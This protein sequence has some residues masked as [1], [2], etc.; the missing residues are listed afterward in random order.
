MFNRLSSKRLMNGIFFW[1][2][3]LFILA[4]MAYFLDPGL[5]PAEYFKDVKLNSIY[6]AYTRTYFRI[7]RIVL[8]LAGACLIWHGCDALS[9]ILTHCEQNDEGHQK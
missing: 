4:V 8:P 1:L 3:V 5:W 6:A 2:V 9:R 7:R